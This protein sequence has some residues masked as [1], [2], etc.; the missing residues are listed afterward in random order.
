M[1]AVIKA[2]HYSPPAP[3][4]GS[5]PMALA[6]MSESAALI[7]MI[8]RAARDVSIPLERLEKLIQM[9]IDAENRELARAYDMAM[10]A[11]QAEMRQVSTDSVNPQTKSRYASYA[12]LDKAL[13][14]IYA[15]SGLVLSFNTE[16]GAPEG[17]IRVVCDVSREGHSKR[18]SVDMPADGKGAKGGDV[19]TKTHAIGSAVTYGRRYLLLMIFNIAVGDDD[20]NAASGG[21]AISPEQLAELVDLC[22]KVGAD[23]MKFCRYMKIE[24]LAALPASRFNE[25]VRALN[26][27]GAK[28]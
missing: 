12:A 14:P 25:A 28:Q 24:S 13:R 21:E 18:Y 1:S 10:A 26:A 27:K 2:D 20:G 5:Q 7:H 19:M 9:R 8:D 22:E 16:P 11:A 4:N 6:P 15:K 3:A 23:K 17:F